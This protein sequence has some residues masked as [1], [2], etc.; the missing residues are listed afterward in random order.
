V[1]EAGREK[2]GRLIEKKRAEKHARKVQQRAVKANRPKI[3]YDPLAVDDEDSQKEEGSSD[4]M[5]A[6]YDQILEEELES[7]KIAEEEDAHELALIKAHKA[8]K[9]EKRREKKR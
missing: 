6:D 4:V 2:L 5:E 8:R 3:E 1:K 7:A 9:R